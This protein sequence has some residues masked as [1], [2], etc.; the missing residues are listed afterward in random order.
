MGFKDTFR[1][2]K[3]CLLW[4]SVIANIMSCLLAS[5]FF[6]FSYSRTIFMEIYVCHS[7]LWP[8]NLAVT[9]WLININQSSRIRLGERPPT[10]IHTHTHTCI[11][12]LTHTLSQ[13]HTQPHIHSHTLTN[14]HTHTSLT[15][16]H[17]YTHTYIHT[18]TYKEGTTRFL[19][20]SQHYVINPHTHYS[21]SIGWM[22]CSNLK[23]S[24]R[25]ASH[26]QQNRSVRVPNSIYPSIICRLS[27][28]WVAGAAT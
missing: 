6:S 26:S 15:H 17:A 22:H 4:N 27:R 13:I 1:C 21:F 24:F 2:W 16:K 7:S 8:L 28:G 10:H 20:I 12:I 3:D 9:P 11:H 19:L 25:N 5:P 14:T 23:P 18:L